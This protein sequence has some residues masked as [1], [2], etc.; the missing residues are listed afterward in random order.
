[1]RNKIYCLIFLL[2]LSF[3]SSKIGFAQVGPAPETFMRSNGKIYVVAVICVTILV[4]LF[5][6]VA[7]IDKKIGRIESDKTGNDL[8]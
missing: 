2:P 4:G 5:L 3:L 8:S 1:M 6:Y 7:S